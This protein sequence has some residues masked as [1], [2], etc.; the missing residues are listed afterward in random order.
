[1]EFT[2]ETVEE[3]SPKHPCA[4]KPAKAMISIF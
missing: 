4:S 3:V 2:I 1:M